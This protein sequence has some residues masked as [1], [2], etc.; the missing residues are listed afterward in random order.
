MD[1]PGFF[2]LVAGQVAE[3]RLA[4]SDWGR[5]L[6]GARGVAWPISISACSCFRFVSSAV[7]TLG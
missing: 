4:P 5:H 6:L 1:A 7:I 3:A 2:C